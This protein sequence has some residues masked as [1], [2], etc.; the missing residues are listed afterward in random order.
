MTAPTL[1]CAP[2]KS[3]FASRPWHPVDQ[4]G[5]RRADPASQGKLLLHQ[6]RQPHI[7]S[8]LRRELQQQELELGLEQELAREQELELEL[9]VMRALRQ[10]AGG[11]HILQRQLRNLLALM[12]Y[13]GTATC[14]LPPSTRDSC[15][16]TAQPFA[17]QP[18]AQKLTLVHSCGFFPL[19]AYQHVD[20]SGSVAALALQ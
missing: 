9:E 18:S 4:P 3:L 10:L 5:P 15:A 2:M 13:C 6:G 8:K 16:G 17:S 11:Q 19:P 14:R 1:V 12:S 20:L 7:S